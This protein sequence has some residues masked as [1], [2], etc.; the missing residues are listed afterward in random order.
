[1]AAWYAGGALRISSHT[2]SAKMTSAH[3]LARNWG[4]SHLTNS[5][6]RSDN[7]N[8]CLVR[9]DGIAYLKSHLKRSDDL[10]DINERSF[11]GF[12]HDVEGTIG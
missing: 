6:W 10:E 7:E 5:P 12:L 8:G 1:M 4:E 2:S 9:R 11:S 3:L